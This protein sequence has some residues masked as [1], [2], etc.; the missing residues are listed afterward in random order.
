MARTGRREHKRQLLKVSLEL[1][2]FAPALFWGGGKGRGGDALRQVSGNRG[3]VAAGSAQSRG[4]GSEWGF[5]PSAERRAVGERSS[6]S[7]G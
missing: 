6:S 4:E 3:R 2:K 7:G 1:G 5:K